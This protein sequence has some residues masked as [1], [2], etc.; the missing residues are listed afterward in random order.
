[1]LHIIE[2]A[3]FMASSLSNHVN[4][5]SGSIYTI[6]CKYGHDDKKYRAK[7]YKYKYCDCF[8]EY[9]KFK[10]DLIGYKYLR[11][12]KKY[13][14]KFDKK[15]KER[16]FNTYKFSNHDNNKFNNNHET[17]LTEQEDFYSDLNMEN[18]TNADYAHTKRVFN[19]FERNKLREYHDMYIQSNTLLLAEYKKYV[20]YQRIVL[21]NLRNMFLK[22][23]ELDPAKKFSAP[24]LAWL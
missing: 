5:L 15:L 14:H 16:F 17:S 20:L 12:N 10:D 6:K 18:I 4:K 1:M 7:E 8:L 2:S 11:C 23:Y 9:R 21:E 3:K 19:G 13:P 24:A 22:I